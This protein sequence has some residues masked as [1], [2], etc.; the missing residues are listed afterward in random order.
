[1]LTTIVGTIVDVLPM[2]NGKTKRG[3]DW[4]TQEYVIKEKK[5]KEEICFC[6]FGK[7]KIDEY[8][9]KKGSV[10]AVSLKMDCTL[11]GDRYLNKVYCDDCFH[12]LHDLSASNEEAQGYVGTTAV[13]W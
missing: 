2:K 1:M 4:Y 8:G 5:T 6:V 11:I 10:V 13:P 12:K 3:N 9:L 7:E